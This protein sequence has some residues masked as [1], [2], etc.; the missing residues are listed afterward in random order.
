MAIKPEASPPATTPAALKRR[1]HE[2]E[3]LLEISR[4]ISA[5][6]SLDAVLATL[7][8]ITTAELGAERGSLFL[9]DPESGELYS[10]VAQGN[11]QREIRIINSS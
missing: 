6:E 4:R 3:L 9:N 11:F 2:A 1:L 5:M 7:V 8:E 10:R